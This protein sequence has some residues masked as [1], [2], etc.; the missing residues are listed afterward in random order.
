MNNIK[1]LLKVGT[2]SGGDTIFAILRKPQSQPKNWSLILWENSCFG[3]FRATT[4]S[5]H[6]MWRFPR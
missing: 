1:E 2:T 3:D 6:S 5:Q 4:A